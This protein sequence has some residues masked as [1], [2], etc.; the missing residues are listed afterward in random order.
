[1]PHHPTP[2]ER[3][4]PNDDNNKTTYVTVSVITIRIT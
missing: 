1:M 3:N 4:T 2:A